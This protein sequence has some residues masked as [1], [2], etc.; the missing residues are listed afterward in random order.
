[1]L[2]EY[3]NAPGVDVFSQE[4]CPANDFGHVHLQWFA[5]ED[6]G[7]TEEPTEYRLRKER[8]EG[9]VPKS[10]DLV[11]AVGLLFTAL[12]LAIVGPWMFSSL[13]DTTRWF[14]SVSTELEIGRA[15]CRERV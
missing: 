15:S 2:L 7:K 8:E 9:R 3:M 1:M 6:E 4:G 13:R 12:T 10:Q 14:L 5:P 11:S